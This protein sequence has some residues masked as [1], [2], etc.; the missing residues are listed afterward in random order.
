[1]K[2]IVQ[3]LLVA[4]IGILAYFCVMSILTPIKFTQEKSNREK[5]VVQ[6]L[7][8]IRT[9]EVEFRDQNNMYTTS[10]S[11]LLNFL[12][13]GKKKTLVKEGVLTDAQLEAGLTEAQAVKIVNSGNQNDIIANNLQHFRRDTVYLDLIP[14]LFG[15]RFTASTIDEIRYVPFSEKKDTFLLEANNGY[16]NVTGLLIPLFQAS[17]KYETYLSDLNRQEL[18][19]AIDLQKKLEKFPG[20]MVGS[21]LEPNN[22]AGNWE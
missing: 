2:T 11:E 18:L 12:K 6:R 20:L 17:C 22:N 1:M 7:M 14:T 9:A 10:F 8:D 4:A 5:Q 21:I 3:I 13:T 16:I 19:N 15:D